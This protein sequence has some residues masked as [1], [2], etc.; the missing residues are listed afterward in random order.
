MAGV[1]G[2]SN[3]PVSGVGILAVVIYASLLVLF[4]TPTA[5]NTP[6]LVAFALFTTTVVFAAAITS[7]DNLQDLKTGQIVG[8][9]PCRQQVAL[10]IGVIAGA[11][12]VPPILN[13]L[14]HA[15]GFA[16]APPN[17]DILGKPLPAPQANLLSALALGVIGEKLNW[18]MI[19]IGAGV[20]VVI[21]VI[22][23]LLGTKKWTRLPPLAVGLGIYLPMS[24]TAAVT[25]GALVGWWYNRRA[26]RQADPMRAQHLG[27]LV[28]S[29]MIVGESLF[30]VLNAG[31]IVAFSKDAPFALVGSD[32]ALAPW[33]GV[34]GF[35]LLIVVLYRWMLRRPSA[36]TTP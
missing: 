6:S 9:A 12:V 23:A 20:G 29:G 15:Y 36:G 5:Q 33:I 32:F 2:S 11:A 34:L 14:A 28:A 22:D 13:L 10:I 31:L 7:N 24:A 27:V 26:E 19:L 18:T 25:L 21:I 8:A 1:I 35:L 4:V 3:S 17:P 30:G 16:G